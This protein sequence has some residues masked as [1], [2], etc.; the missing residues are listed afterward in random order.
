M[1]ANCRRAAAWM[2]TAV[3]GG[4]GSGAEAGGPKARRRV[5]RDVGRSGIVGLWT[6]GAG[7]GVS[8]LSK[9]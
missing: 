7:G 9:R 8:S 4:E 6:C 3:A 5:A 2:H 1:R